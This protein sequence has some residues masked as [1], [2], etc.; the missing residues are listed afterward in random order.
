LFVVVAAAIGA[1]A[2][3]AFTRGE[4]I[5]RALRPS[6]LILWG[7][8]AGAVATLVVVAIGFGGQVRQRGY[9]GQLSEADVHDGD[10]FWIGEMPL[11]L[12]G[13]DAPELTQV[14]AG[15][16]DCGGAA[17]RQLLEIVGD[18]LLRCEQKQRRSGSYVESFGRP[19]VQCWVR[20]GG[21]PEFD[22]GEQLISLGFAVQYEGDLSFG[23]ASAEVKGRDLGI[24]TG[25]SLAPEVWRRN[26]GARSEFI[27]TRAPPSNV[28]SMGHCG[29]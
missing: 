6:I 29:R 15:A 26:R 1:F 25:C 13:V 9:F 17:R 14:C 21:E 23:Y 7:F 2:L 3:L 27:R 19:L 24:M 5:E 16:E 22:L 28:R 12:W 18:G 20:K 10:T 11:R 4:Q 8:M